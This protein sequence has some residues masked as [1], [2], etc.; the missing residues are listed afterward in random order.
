[1]VNMA[2]ILQ[3]ITQ[4]HDAKKNISEFDS[5]WTGYKGRMV[6][7]DPLTGKTLG[8]CRSQ[9]QL[10]GHHRRVVDLANDVSMA[11]EFGRTV[12]VSMHI[13]EL[14]PPCTKPTD[15]L[16]ATYLPDLLINDHNEGKY[17]LVRT[18]TSAVAL[19]ALITIVE[20][21]KGNWEQLVINCYDHLHSGEDLLPKGSVLVIKQPFFKHT[22]NS[23]F[24]IIVDHISDM[25][26]MLPTNDMVP[27]QWAAPKKTAE[28]WNDEGYAHL[29]NGKYRRAAS[30]F[31]C[32]IN[33]TSYENSQSEIERDARVGRSRA[34]NKLGMW[35]KAMFDSQLA[36]ALNRSGDAILQNVLAQYHLQMT[37]GA[38]GNL[39]RSQHHFSYDHSFYNVLMEKIME[40]RCEADKGLFSLRKM[41]DSHWNGQQIES[42]DYI[43]LVDV[44]GAGQ[45]VWFKDGIKDIIPGQ[46]V[47]VTKAI[48]SCPPEESQLFGLYDHSK[49]K[50]VNGNLFTLARRVAEKLSSNPQHCYKG[51]LTDI[52][53]NKGYQGL[54]EF[55][56]IDGT[57]VIDTY[58]IDL[59]PTIANKD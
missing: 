34:Y 54:R 5:I 15:E 53:L 44:R 37:Q 3:T 9:K 59:V 40:R 27:K 29:L 23:A 46:L 20:D 7:P 50:T 49:D 31:G 56:R 26:I 52:R 51:Y 45:G 2:S 16:L 30:C 4:D 38:M 43:E 18:V 1:M 19:G 55:M 32:A 58:V 42:H 13:F 28:E 17:I 48:A 35:E 24:F 33:L 6:S 57:M 10:L 8:K 25:I 14:Y 41:K 21:E 47:L 36:M 39:L 22:P 11:K 12:K